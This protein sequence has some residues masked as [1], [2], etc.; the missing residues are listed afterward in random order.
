M[1]GQWLRCDVDNVLSR[2]RN[3]AQ[4]LGARRKKAGCGI[5]RERIR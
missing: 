3:A 4:R 2:V 1:V 5:S